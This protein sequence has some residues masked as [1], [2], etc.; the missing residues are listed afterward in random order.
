MNLNLALEDVR[1]R[2]HK[3]LIAVLRL[4]ARQLPPLALYKLGHDAL[5]ETCALLVLQGQGHLA[6]DQLLEPLLIRL[7]LISNLVALLCQLENSLNRL[8]C[9]FYTLGLF[10]WGKSR[11]NEFCGRRFD[12]HG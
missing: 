11:E 12:V 1:Q 2:N 5:H 4:I 3:H 7:Q 8:H 6:T 9:T 10:I